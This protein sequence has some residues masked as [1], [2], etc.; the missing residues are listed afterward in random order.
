[1]RSC[2]SLWVGDV[3]G[4]SL[5]W[6]SKQKSLEFVAFLLFFHILGLVISNSHSSQPKACTG[7]YLSFFI[8]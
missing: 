2:H 7:F 3:A 4:S 8:F 5:P 6:Y 1:M